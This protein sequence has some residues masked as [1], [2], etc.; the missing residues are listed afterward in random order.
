M[1]AG[2]DWT[3]V[4]A[5]YLKNSVTSFVEPLRVI[6]C[7]VGLVFCLCFCFAASGILDDD[8]RPTSESERLVDNASV[9]SR[10]SHR[11]G[12][13]QTRLVL[14]APKH[15]RPQAEHPLHVLCLL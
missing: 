5:A 8:G 10:V 15:D 6:A 9:T 11:L 4:L 13:I 7:R 12:Y 2:L 14:C 3:Y 1:V